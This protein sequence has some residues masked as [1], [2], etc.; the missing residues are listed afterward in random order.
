[1]ANLSQMKRERMLA[2]LDII[3]K[4]HKDD[5]DILRA[6]GEIES[7]LN[8]K[9]YGLVWEEHEEAVDVQMQNNI[10]VFTEIEDREICTLPNDGYN[11]L[12]EGDNLHSLRLLEKTH[13]GKI[14]V[15][16][17]DPPYNTGSKDFKYNDNFVDKL[18]GYRHSKW[19]SFMEKRLLIAKKL[20][21]DKGAIFISIDDNEEA[22]L[23]LL[24]DEI[25]GEECFVANISWQRTYSPRNDSK[26][27]SSE[28]EHILLYSSN[29]LWNP[30]K[31]DRTEKMDSIYKSPD[32]DPKPW[33]SSCISRLLMASF[34]EQ[35]GRN[36]KLI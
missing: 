22:P 14:D 19:I 27:L 25:F 29:I 4:E 36:A 9:K 32:H 24:C 23:K 16:Y 31:L 13:C 34:A 1:M 20:L 2:F 3:R 17:I 18:D 26:G 35:N 30:N 21:S 11:F 5:D 28:V 8:S 15:I 6:L 33:T 10:P 12:L 7:A